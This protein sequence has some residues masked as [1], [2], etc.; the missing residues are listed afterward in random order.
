MR[1]IPSPCSPTAAGYHYPVH[2]TQSREREKHD[3]N[4]TR[5]IIS[6]P[7]SS[8]NTALLQLQNLVCF[9]WQEKED[10]QF[11]KWDLKDFPKKG[12]KMVG[13]I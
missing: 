1:K 4:R 10:R 6:F 5:I 11:I 13:Q 3:I 2:L 8:C 9:S 7:D 12:V